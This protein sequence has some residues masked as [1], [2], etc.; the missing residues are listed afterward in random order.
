MGNYNP[1]REGTG[2]VY[3]YTSLNTL[4]NIL[5]GVKDEKFIFHATN[6]FS[7]N[8]P[9]EFIHGFKQLW[10]I[11]PKIEN[12]LYNLI[13]NKSHSY[14]IEEIYLDKKYRLSNMWNSMNGSNRGW[15][16]AYVETIRRT[17][18][19]PFVVSFS[20]HDDF[21]PMWSTYGDNGNGTAIG[22]EIQDYYIKTKRDDGTF[23]YDFTRIDENE[24]RSIMVSYEQ[25]T[26][27]HLLAKF[28]RINIGNYLRTIPEPDINNETLLCLQMKALDNIVKLA[29]ALI[30]N[31]AY[32]YEAESRLISYKED[33]RDVN[34]KIS[35][36]KKVLPYI[37]IGIPMS[38]LKKI[39]I[40]PCCNYNEVKLALKTRFVQLGIPLKD[41]DIIKSKVPYRVV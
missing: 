2:I 18:D 28:A 20:C 4:F 26:I 36:T 27:D 9:T 15:I 8:D 37:K 10:A 3:H 25:V 40:G 35:P 23:L 5:D 1:M 29:S 33:I 14:N 7:M 12:D 16:K 11:L 38:K 34:F 32:K 24:L 30:K 17:Y 21:L 13:R 31:K 22:I 19:S 39:V 6:I 41:E